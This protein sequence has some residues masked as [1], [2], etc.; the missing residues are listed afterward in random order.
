MMLKNVVI[1]ISEYRLAHYVYVQ[2]LSS[3]HEVL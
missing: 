2:M 3:E 1:N